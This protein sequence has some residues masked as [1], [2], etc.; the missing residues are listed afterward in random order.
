MA[1]K[2]PIHNHHKRNIIIALT[3]VLLVAIMAAGTYFALN[4]VAKLGT[5][6]ESAKESTDNSPDAIRKKAQDLMIKNDLPAAKEAYTTALAG[7]EAEKDQAAVADIK[8]QLQ[9]ID[10]AMSAPKEPQNTDRGRVTIG[11][12]AKQ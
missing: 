1:Y 4:Q 12:S 6:K 2:L 5:T 8:M 7:Y 11:N 9:M 3:S 10:T